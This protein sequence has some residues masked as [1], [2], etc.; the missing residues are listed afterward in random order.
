MQRFHQARQYGVLV[1]AV[2][3]LRDADEVLILRGK[4]LNELPGLVAGAVVYEQHPAFLAHKALC[5]EA[6]DLFQKHGCRDGQ[7]LLL[8]V[9]GDHDPEDRF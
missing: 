3:A 8:V 4:A 7:H 9:A 2:A 1:A 6:L 5:S